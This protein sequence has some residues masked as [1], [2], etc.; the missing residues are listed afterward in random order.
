MQTVTALLINLKLALQS[1]IT[2]NTAVATCK[3]EK[4]VFSFINSA[5]K[6]LICIFKKQIFILLG[7]KMS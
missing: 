5:F 6:R 7:K 4:Q 2:L 3:I 1:W